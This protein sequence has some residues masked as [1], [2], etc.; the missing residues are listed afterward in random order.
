MNMIQ[1]TTEEDYEKFAMF[2]LRNRNAFD[3]AFDLPYT[4]LDALGSL[5][6]MIK[7]TRILFVSDEQQEVIGAVCYSYGTRGNHFED[8]HVVFVDCVLIIK[9]YRS[10]LFF[11][12][13]FL[14]M[15]EHIANENRNVKEFRFYAH[16][17]H[18]YVHRLYSKFATVIAEIEDYSGIKDV[19]SVEFDGLVQYLEKFR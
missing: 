3:D 8:K 15:I 14:K 13:Y 17:T 9:E 16:R 1:C 7:E 2:Y 4:V 12:R 18:Q 11:V 5:T 19:Y 6:I 10:S